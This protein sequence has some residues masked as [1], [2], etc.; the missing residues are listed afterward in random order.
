MLLKVFIVIVLLVIVGSLFS[1]LFYLIK[2][3]GEGSRTAKALTLRIS[4]SLGLFLL[5]MILYYFGLIGQP[6]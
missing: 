6:R 4:L 3:K 2:D 1:A 5:L